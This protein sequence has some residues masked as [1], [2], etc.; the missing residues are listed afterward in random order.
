[1]ETLVDSGESAAS[2]ESYLQSRC[3]RRKHSRDE[4]SD[5]FSKFKKLDDAQK[6]AQ[7]VST[8]TEQLTQ[9]STVLKML[10]ELSNDQVDE[11]VCFK[12]NIKSQQRK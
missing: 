3:K 2:A 11:L 6:A 12:K 4:L 7:K 5:S 1:M 8:R 9:M 10:R